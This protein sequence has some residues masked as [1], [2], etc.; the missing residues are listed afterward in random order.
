ME[1]ENLLGGHLCW[2]YRGSE[3][4][5]VR[6]PRFRRVSAKLLRLSGR[7]S[8]RSCDNDNILETVVVQSLAGQANRFLPLVMR[9]VLRLA[10]AALDENARYTAL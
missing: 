9:E 2:P 1:L 10:V 8:S 3:Y 5:A 7:L 6:S 4:E